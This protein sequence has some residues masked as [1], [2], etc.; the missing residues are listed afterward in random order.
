MLI[1]IFVLLLIA[2]VGIALIVSSGTETALAG[3]YRSSTVVY[4]AAL[5]GMEEGR[6]RLMPKN[7]N[8]INVFPGPPGT[9]LPVGQV[10]YITNPANG[11]NVLT[12]YQDNEYNTEFGLGALAGATVST[13]PSVSPVAGIQGPLY[14][15]VRINAVTE[16]SLNFDVD[17]DG[18]L[19]PGLI[20]YDGAH[21]TT[22]PTGAQALEITSLA[23]LPNGT[24][25]MAQYIV[26]PAT[27]NL[28]FPGALILD[29]N[30]VVFGPGPTTFQINGNDEA[31]GTCAA[32]PPVTA[33]GY[34]GAPSPQ[35]NATPAGNYIGPGGT[36][37]VNPVT[38]A[39]NLQSVSGLNALVATIAQNADVTISGPANAGNMPTSMSAANP[40]T[41]VV[42]GDLDLNG[43]FSTGYGILL[44]TGNLHYDPGASWEG[45][46][47]VIGKG[48]ITSDYNGTGR[49]DGAV[50]L[51]TT[52]DSAN[53]PL[54]SLGTPSFTFLTG[55]GGTGIHYS[56]C[57]IK[58]VQAPSTYTVLSFHEILQ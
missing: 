4:Y 24:Q 23:V 12:T 30:G 44:V 15:W 57:W 39:S 21:L 25:K 54:S 11:E 27:L 28:N 20:Y 29:G 56:S 53:N 52:V 1:A 14:R 46:V 55:D 17:N 5:A 16:Q 31:V 51:A 34:T 49:F 3:N 8:Y 48:T 50:F 13:I 36:P 9:P 2:V 19:G 38:L 42:N 35:L 18:S 33:I 37:S 47:L 58:A 43:W 40:L 26:A 6:G 10:W 41:V 22:N 32:G 7:A 45:I